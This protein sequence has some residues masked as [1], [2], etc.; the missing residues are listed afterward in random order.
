M[1]SEEG[2][3][4]VDQIPKCHVQTISQHTTNHTRNGDLPERW[5][6]R[7]TESSECLAGLDAERMASFASQIM[8]DTKRHQQALFEL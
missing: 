4:I 7:K 2:V 1:S 5:V 6:A 3:F 8:R